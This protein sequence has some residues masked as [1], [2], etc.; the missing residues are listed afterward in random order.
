MAML[1]SFRL[2]NIVNGSDSR[3]GVIVHRES[4]TIAL[5]AAL[6]S[7][8]LLVSLIST[9][10]GGRDGGSV[11]KVLIARRAVAMFTSLRLI[12]VIDRGDCRSGVVIY[13]KRITV[14]VLGTMLAV[15]L[16]F[17]GLLLDLLG[18]RDSITL[19]RRN[20]TGE[21]EIITAATRLLG[22]AFL[23]LTLGWG[24]DHRAGIITRNIAR[25]VN[26][27]E[28]AGHGEDIIFGRARAWTLPVQLLNDLLGD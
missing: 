18:W 23:R 9:G 28:A 13:R 14:A 24:G 19:T 2:V 16:L 27:L 10:G 3:S 25:D 7:L 26:T 17:I 15:C 6:A 20:L 21:L 4:I 11:I 5:G 1:A 8:G 12:Q 22:P